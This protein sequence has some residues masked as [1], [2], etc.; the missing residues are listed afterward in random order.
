MNERDIQRRKD[1]VIRAVAWNKAHPGRNREATARYRARQEATIEG[2]RKKHD[3]Y[4]RT[5]YGISLETYEALLVSQNG[6]CAICGE[7]P[8]MKHP[9]P[10]RRLLVV[11]HCHKHKQ[12][13]GLL[14]AICNHVLGVALDNPK[15]LR[16]AA[17]YVEVFNLMGGPVPYVT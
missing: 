16:M 14:C 6:L 5:T 2:R 9:H 10:S 7:P 13:R 12:V 17:N 1:A 3:A 4:L 11:D 15:R 8:N